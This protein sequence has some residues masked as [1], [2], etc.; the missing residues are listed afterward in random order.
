MPKHADTPK[1]AECA[2]LS[3]SRRQLLT[4]LAVLGATPAD[5]RQQPPLGKVNPTP[6][7]SQDFLKGLDLKA[8]GLKGFLP[9]P[10][11]LPE[12]ILLI[13]PDDLVVL[14]VQWSGLAK[15]PNGAQLM[16]AQ[17]GTL[18][19]WFPGQHL[20]EEALNEV[21]NAVQLKPRPMQARLAERTRLVFQVPAGTSFPYTTEGILTACEKLPMILPKQHGK[22]PGEKETRIEFPTDLVLTPS[23]ATRIRKRSGEVG[24]DGWNE[25]W[26]AGLASGD[27]VR[28]GVRASYAVPWAPSV[29][30]P[31]QEPNTPVRDD[32]RQNL[33][34]S[35]ASGPSAEADELTFSSLGAW[36]RLRYSNPSGTAPIKEWV[37]YSAMG[38][39]YYVRIVTRGA[40]FPLG[41]RAVL[42]EVSERRFESEPGTGASVAYLVKYRFLTVLEPSKTYTSRDFP[43]VRVT[44]NRLETPKLDSNTSGFFWPTVGNAA[45]LWPFTATDHAGQTVSSETQLAFVPEGYTGALGNAE[46]HKD[47]LRCALSGQNLALAPAGKPGD[48]TY[49]ADDLRMKFV[50]TAANFTPSLYDARLRVPALEELTGSAEAIAVRYYDAYVAKGFADNPTE[51]F[52]SLA[53]KAGLNLPE[54]LSG[55]VIAPDFTFSNLARKLGPVAGVQALTGKFDPSEY[56]EDLTILGGIKVKDILWASDKAPAALQKAGDLLYDLPKLVSGEADKQLGKTHTLEWKTNKFHDQTILKDLLDFKAFTSKGKTELR[57]LLVSSAKQAAKGEPKNLT[58]ALS[59]FSLSLLGILRVEFERLQ[60]ESKGGKKPDVIADIDVV[61]TGALAFFNAL[62]PLIPRDGFSDPPFLDVTFSGVTAGYNL[63]LPDLSIG[64]FN[65]K[66]LSLGASLTLPFFGDPMRLRFNF[67]EAHKPFLVAVGIFGGGGYLALEATTKGLERVECSLEFGGVLAVN[68]GVAA[69]TVT[70]MAGLQL[71]VEGSSVTL[72]GYLRANGTLKILGLIT[73]TAEILLVME[74]QSATGIVAGEAKV[75]VT[76]EFA[77]FSKTVRFSFRKEFAG[78]KSAEQL[79]ESAEYASLESGYTQPAPDLTTLLSPSDW[80]DYRSAF[81]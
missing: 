56:F 58:V 36:V 51:T 15:S 81:A 43:F 11:P 25:L 45:I 71:I 9:T 53:S 64:V 78:G 10:T 19:L 37:H 47:R 31:P 62:A 34:K 40:L 79:P 66:N 18:T 2:E 49:R 23:S 44:L 20:Q 46:A 7:N 27:L 50:G 80:T 41:H 29:E 14:E 69:G 72:R 60:F 3:L 76:V 67:C 32:N 35:M 33:V 68:L 30:V 21:G 73:I 59:N 22:A 28:L 17:G 4:W 57:F 48:T 39:D 6:G 26:R 13:R 70:I 65:L 52:L 8:Q 38:R 54:S 12:S 61:F 75:A 5:A 24:P 74:Y 16:S 63:T 55:G 77:F 42:T 1:H